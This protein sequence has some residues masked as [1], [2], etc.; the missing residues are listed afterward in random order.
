MVTHALV[1]PRPARS[2]AGRGP[3]LAAAMFALVSV[4]ALAARGSGG[5][6]MLKV[7]A[8]A[9]RN[10]VDT[11]KLVA[12][13][14]SESQGVALPEHSTPTHCTLAGTIVKVNPPDFYCTELGAAE[15][16][17]TPQV[18]AAAKRMQSLQE[19]ADAPPDYA[20]GD[21]GTDVCPDGYSTIDNTADCR[22]AAKALLFTAHESTAT[23]AEANDAA[24]A[25]EGCV[26][27]VDAFV[28]FNTLTG[29]P[30][31]AINANEFKVCKSDTAGP[32]EEDLSGSVDSCLDCAGNCLSPAAAFANRGPIVDQA[33]GFVGFEGWNP[34]GAADNNAEQYIDY[35]LGGKGATVKAIL[36]ANAGDTTHDP[37][38]IK[39]WSSEDGITYDLVQEIDV[40][41]LQ[42]DDSISVVA[43]ANDD[44]R[45]KYWRV[46]PGGIEKQSIPRVIGLCN[47][48]DCNSCLYEDRNVPEQG[49][50][51]YGAIKPAECP[52]GEPN[53]NIYCLGNYDS[54]KDLNKNLEKSY[55]IP[56]FRDN[57]YS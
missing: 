15:K 3:A 29:G 4:A 49:Y 10:S 6:H 40:S 16:R 21:Q 53:G 2:A 43:V 17:G 51:A 44:V 48:A 55:T 52:D 7:Q 5:A 22:A 35:D 46:N 50:N 42:G 32:A 31:E 18:L 45:A 24:D 36:W 14:G 26:Y 57:G 20:M 54:D 37:A 25:P 23:D 47:T 34:Q 1:A 13:P 41:A 19:D 28:F 12:I 38:N 11:E 30:T 8:L 27:Y 9:M 39:L 33:A 56:M